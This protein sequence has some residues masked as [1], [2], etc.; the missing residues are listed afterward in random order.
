MISDE[1]RDE[2]SQKA[3]AR[4]LCE[5]RYGTFQRSFAIPA[6]ATIEAIAES[7]DASV[8]TARV[9][10]GYAGSTAQRIAISAIS[11]ISK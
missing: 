8:M 2:H 5:T 9:T 10:V 11:A 6:H 4:T 1:R 3:Q 7:C